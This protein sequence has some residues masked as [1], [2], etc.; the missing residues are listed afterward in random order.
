MGNCGNFIHFVD[1]KPKERVENTEVLKPKLY[2]FSD[3]QFNLRFTYYTQD[4][5]SFN[6]DEMTYK[7]NI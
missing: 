1:E 7:E 6:I 2:H 3:L 5:E 4:F